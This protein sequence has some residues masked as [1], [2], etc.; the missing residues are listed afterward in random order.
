MFG[1]GGRSPGPTGAGARPPPPRGGGSGGQG[2]PVALDT[3]APAAPSQD[4]LTPCPDDFLGDVPPAKSWKVRALADISVRDSIVCE[5]TQVT[6]AELSRVWL[7]LWGMSPVQYCVTQARALHCDHVVGAVSHCGLDCVCTGFGAPRVC[8]A[9]GPHS[10]QHRRDAEGSDCMGR[11]LHAHSTP[12]AASPRTK[13]GTQR[14]KGREKRRGRG[15]RTKRPSG[16]LPA[17]RP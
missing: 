2:G 6:R 14:P 15:K 13:L 8:S 10:D 9:A 12:K 11:S 5:G 7:V 3:T 16:N 4:F 1:G 17:R